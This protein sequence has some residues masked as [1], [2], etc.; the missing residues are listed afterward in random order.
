ML[1]MYV[2]FQS[3]VPTLTIATYSGIE[4]HK[5]DHMNT[6]TLNI[7]EMLGLD[8]V[9]SSIAPAV[10]IAQLANPADSQAQIVALVDGNLKHAARQKVGWLVDFAWPFVEPELET[11]IASKYV[12]PGTTGNTSA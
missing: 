9:E 12:A 11:V 2:L 6:S 1:A 10:Q 4:Y 3:T 5:K 8:A 7:L